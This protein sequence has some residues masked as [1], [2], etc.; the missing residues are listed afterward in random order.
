MLRFGQHLIKPS[1]VFLRTELCFALVNRRPVVPG[2]ILP[3]AGPWKASPVYLIT[4]YNYLKGG[5]GEVEISVFSQGQSSGLKLFR[6][7]VRLDMS[8]N[9]H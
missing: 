8:K 9:G 7:G 5:C 1:V 2:R 6:G 4:L 3:L